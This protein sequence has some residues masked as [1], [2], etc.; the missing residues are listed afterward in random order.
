MAEQTTEDKVFQREDTGQGGRMT[1]AKLGALIRSQDVS[2]YERN[3][4]YFRVEN[5]ALAAI[6]GPKTTT[7]NNAIPL[8]YGRK[9]V[10]DAVGY[11]G[12]PGKIKYVFADPDPETEEKFRDIEK[13]NGLG[14]TTTEIFQD[15]LVS[16][17][18]AE[19]A[20][21]D[22]EENIPRFTQITTSSEILTMTA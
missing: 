7:P 2:Q 10:F 18:G 5:E 3:R 12:K 22:G 15:A 17:Q 9:T 13:R 16:G 19:L 11:A 6:T 8:P 14:L 1:G 4:K 20:W 21:F